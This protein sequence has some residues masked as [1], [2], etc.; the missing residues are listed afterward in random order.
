MTLRVTI[1]LLQGLADCQVQGL[2]E[3][4]GISN[5]KADRVRQASR[6]LQVGL[7]PMKKVQMHRF[8]GM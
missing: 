1:A 5:F 6:V 8:H 3:A 4:V 7:P 2:T